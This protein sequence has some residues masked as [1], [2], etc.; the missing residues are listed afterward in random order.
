MAVF[1]TALL[2]L[3][4]CGGG[5]AEVTSTPKQTV[6][7]VSVTPVRTAIADAVTVSPSPTN[8]VYTVKDGDVLGAIADQ[9]G[10]SVDSLMQA[11]N[12]TDPASLY[13]GQKLDIPGAQATPRP[14]PPPST[15]NADSPI[16]I[17]LQMPVGGA[18]LTPDDDQMPNAPREY[19][20][21][22]HEGI[23][24]FTDY[25]CVPVPINLPAL[26]AADG[27]IIRMDKEYRPLSQKEIDDLEA[28]SA[29]QGFTDE[30][31]LDKFRGRQV[32][33]DHG[34]GIITRYCHLNA[35]PQALGVGS[36]VK[37]GDTIGY[38]GDTGTPESASQPEFEIHLHFE[39]RVADSY[40]AAGDGPQDTRNA[41]ERAFGLPLTQYTPAP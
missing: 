39:V 13:V 27:T 31:T 29:V 41:Y 20:A 25:A 9:F 7:G 2:L 40:L 14:T 19:R 18:C 26:A 10:V 11:N 22:V 34:N 32:W 16:G 37:A 36:H 15:T 24:F 28:K 1:A 17:V 21:G 6:A 38:I 23:D 5:S 30:G 35:V 33:I 4:A 8:F 12:I 3:G